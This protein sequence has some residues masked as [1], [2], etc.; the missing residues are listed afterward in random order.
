VESTGA[1]NTYETVPQMAART[2]ALVG[3]NGGFFDNSG[4]PPPFGFVSMLKL[5]GV[6]VAPNPTPRAALGAGGSP[7]ATFGFA[8]EPVTAGTPDPLASFRDAV[9]AGPFIIMPA[10]QPSAAVTAWSSEPGGFDWVCSAHP[11]SAAW[12]LANGHLMLG[13]FDGGNAQGPNDG[14]GFWLDTPTSAYCNGSSAQNWN[15]V[16][17]GQFILQNFP[18]TRQAMNLDGGGSST[19]VVNGVVVNGQSNGASPR[20]V[21]DGLMVFAA[22]PPR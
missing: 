11:R 5:A 9:G 2:G 8:V 4:S 19:F 6:L 21:I 17:L 13:T 20:A 7:G 15:G 14:L 22:A 12:L 10:P 1:P 16:S 3:I 18:T